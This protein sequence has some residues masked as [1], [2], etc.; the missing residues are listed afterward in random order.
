MCQP[1]W[2]RNPSGLSSSGSITQNF[3]KRSMSGG[4]RQAIPYGSKM[5]RF[6]QNLKNLKQQLKIWNRKNFGNILESQKQLT[7]QMRMVQRHI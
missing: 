6:Q 3:N 1:P 2:G 5:Y 4:R 7:D